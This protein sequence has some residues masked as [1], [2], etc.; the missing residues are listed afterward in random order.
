[1][2]I[3]KPVAATDLRGLSRLAIDATAELV[4]VIEAV[5]EAV[6]KPFGMLVPPIHVPVRGIRKLAYS[7]VRGITQLVGATLDIVLAQLAPL[8]DQ[9][10]HW[11]G[12]DALQAALN[13]VLGDYLVSS[14]NPLAIRM[15]LRHDGQRLAL[16]RVSVASAIPQATGKI[17][18]LAHGLCMNDQQWTREGQNYGIRLATDLGYTPV[19][20]RYNSGLHISTNG[21]ELAD[22]LE[23]LIKAWPVP[24]EELALIGHSMGGLLARSACHYAQQQGYQWPRVLRRM[25]FIGSPHLGAPL[26]RGGN[27]VQMI[28]SASPFTAPFARLGKI[29]SSAITDLRHGSLIDED[30]EGRDRFE[31]SPEHP[32]PV[33]LPDGVSCYAIAGTAS[34]EPDTLKGKLL[35]DGLVYPDSALGRHG[36]PE[37]TLAL[38]DE[39]TWVA[40]GVGHIELI[41]HPAVYERILEWFREPAERPRAS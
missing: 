39:R 21:R 40:Y 38:P 41:N 11:Q 18:V 26:E 12:R 25:V 23:A 27:W 34:R 22:S 6:E 14:D 7:S 28:L 19:F 35:G 1:M 13:G 37:R 5:H 15:S 31:H 33:P 16:D 24:A 4:D 3:D 8:L 10:S 9:D 29:R 20:L 36:I 17:V 32:Q 2:D 30:W